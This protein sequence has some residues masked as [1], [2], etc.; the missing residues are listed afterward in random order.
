M[1]AHSPLGCSREACLPQEGGRQ[2]RKHQRR[3]A[4][5]RWRRASPSSS[6]PSS[7]AVSLS[8]APPTWSGE[9][10]GGEAEGGREGKTWHQLANSSHKP[11]SGSIG[12]THF[13]AWST[14]SLE[15]NGTQ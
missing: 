1:R 15:P 11:Y 6:S 3:V 8:S 4:I 7:S 12:S 14:H 9:G 5:G 13:L 2:L 10:G